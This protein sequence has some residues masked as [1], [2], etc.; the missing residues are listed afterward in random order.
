MKKK[1]VIIYNEIKSISLKV[2][3]VKAQKT[4][5]ITGSFLEAVEAEATTGGV[6]SDK[7]K[8]REKSRKKTDVIKTKDI[9]VFLMGVRTEPTSD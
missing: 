8:P 6:N 4:E 3:F 2:V 5:E 1:L 7:D 9:Q